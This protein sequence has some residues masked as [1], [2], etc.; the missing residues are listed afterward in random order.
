[1]PSVDESTHTVELYSDVSDDDH[2]ADCNTE[3]M[4]DVNQLEREYFESLHV[5][6]AA[7]NAM[8]V[9][10]PV[11]LHRKVLTEFEEQNF[12]VHNVTPD[13]PCSA[14]FKTDSFMPASEVFDALKKDGFRNEH[15]RCLHRKPTGEI[16]ITFRTNELRDTFLSKSSF[17]TRRRSFAPNDS[18]RPLSFLTVYDAPYELP[19]A[20]IIHRLS[21]YCEVVWY[22]RGTYKNYGGVFN[23]LRHFRVRVKFA[24][25]SYL[26]FGKFLVRLYHDGQT[27]TCRRCN[28]SGHKAAD[29]RKTVCFNCDGLGHT[30]KECIRPMYCCICKS[31]Q[32]LARTCPFSWHRE[33]ED[34]PD[35][36]PPPPPEYGN[37]GDYPA[38]DDA[39]DE[40]L[41]EGDPDLPAEEQCDPP[42]DPPLVE[43]STGEHTDQPAASRR[44]IVVD[45]ESVL[46]EELETSPDVTESSVL[47]SVSASAD[48]S[49]T[50]PQDSPVV[51]SDGFLAER[52]PPPVSDTVRNPASTLSSSETETNE[53][54]SV[55]AA[56]ELS[57]SVPEKTWADIVD[58]SVPPVGPPQN[59]EK[60]Q[61]VSASAPLPQRAKTTG[62]RPAT[63]PSLIPTLGRKPTQPAKV[64]T[65]RRQ[66]ELPAETV[67]ES[68]DTSE[69]SRKRKNSEDASGKRTPPQPS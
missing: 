11:L 55:P 33:R 45:P 67:S 18:E 16:F 21:P 69:G 54:M 8:F 38:S 5:E 48:I 42:T 40:S 14:F 24:I 63:A 23:G 1:M 49:P 6:D 61:P 22:R 29:C 51:N 68:M 12:F 35:D 39:T 10:S 13:R 7:P 27:P 53:K 52:Q 41:M 65:R 66:K 28:R 25:P 44:P 57:V 9:D 47:E 36:T 64:P 62:R 56:E 60:D 34:P 43:N 37:F 19:D 30:S 26:R 32:H 59:P 31:G 17:V 58:S 2:F 4:Q 15:I 20:A 3:F 46:A 50:P